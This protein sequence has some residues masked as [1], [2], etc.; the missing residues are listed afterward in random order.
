MRHIITA[1]AVT[2]MATATVEAQTSYNDL[3]NKYKL[4]DGKII[5]LD[6]SRPT[7]AEIDSVSMVMGSFFYDQFRHFDDP[8]APYFMFMSRD[9]NL[10]MGIGGSVRIKGWYEWGGAMPING[11]SPSFIPIPENPAQSRHLGANASGT[12]LFFR[13]MGDS[14]KVGRYQFYIEGGFSGYQYIDFKLKKAYAQLRDWTVGLTTSTFSDPMAMA[15]DF[16]ASGMNAK[17]DDTRV[18]LRYMPTF[19]GKYTVALSA[20]YPDQERIQEDAGKT[21]AT[22][23]WMP[24]FAAFLQWQWNQSNHIRLA[25]ILRTLG[26]RNLLTATNHTV[27]GWGTQLSVVAN[28]TPRLALYGTAS[29]GRGL[30]ST[31]NDLQAANY[32]LVGDPDANPGRLY[33]PRQYGW[34]LGAMYS[35]RP[36]WFVD[37]TV[38]QVRYL[39]RHREDPSDYKY[40]MYAFA[41]MCYDIT[42]R[43]TLAGQ[44]TWGLRHNIDGAHKAARRVEAVAMFS[45]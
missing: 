39:P 15:P 42:P 22:S 16:D 32:D 21:E 18:L 17:F 24:D 23:T 34:S 38:S 20:E 25:G 27:M 43:I 5:A 19:G 37:A 14:K 29:Y 45:F 4:E 35:I 41:C 13:V 3:R 1:L 6:G 10:S 2:L 30:A 11:L 40:G 33:A 28:A 9:A 7:Q 44:F 8:D 31:T 36:G 26:Y 12:G